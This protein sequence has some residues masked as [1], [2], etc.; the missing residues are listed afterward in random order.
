MYKRVV[1]PLDGSAVAEAILPFVLSIAGP[2]DLAVVLLRV[3]PWR[4]PPAIER[5]SYSPVDDIQT[6]MDKACAYLAG[7]ARGLRA[8]AAPSP[9]RCGVAQTSRCF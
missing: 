6:S 5:G 9:K 1:I 2:L 7:I 8:C 3:V 4:P